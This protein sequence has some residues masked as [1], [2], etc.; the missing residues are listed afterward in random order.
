MKVYKVYFNNDSNTWI[1]LNKGYLHFSNYKREEYNRRNE[2]NNQFLNIKDC[3]R[4]CINTFDEDEIKESLFFFLDLFDAVKYISYFNNKFG[5]FN[6]ISPEYKIL[7]LELPYELI[8]KYFGIGNYEFEKE[9]TYN[10]A[11]EIAI[12]FDELRKAMTNS[13]SDEKNIVLDNATIYESNDSLI[14]EIQEFLNA[15]PNHKSSNYMQC[16]EQI[17]QILGFKIILGTLQ[18]SSTTGKLKIVLDNPQYKVFLLNNILTKISNE[19]NEIM[20]NI[21]AKNK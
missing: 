12:P 17:L 21:N 5:N 8:L 13:L 2:F 7:E 14:V 16:I 6:A 18:K 15:N 10:L 9:F 19:I 3:Y 1:P 4:L 20:N 11:P